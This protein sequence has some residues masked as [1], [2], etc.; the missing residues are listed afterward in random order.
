MTHIQI[1]D[2]KINN[3]RSLVKSLESISGTNVSVCDN[4]SECKSS[5]LTILPGVGKFGIASKALIDFGFNDV[6][7]ETFTKGDKI[8]G[9]CLGMQL[10]GNESEESP[11]SAGLGLIPGTSKRL[12]NLSGERIPHIG[13]AEVSK[14]DQ[15]SF[16]PAQISEKDFYFVH[17]YYFEPKSE[18]NIISKTPYGSFLFPSIIG[19]DDCVIGVQFHPEKSSN[20]GQQFL[21]EII[22]WA[23]E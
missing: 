7:S 16:S 4:Y 2:L 22:K 8:L 11:G 6:L 17:S 23:N 5:S 19:I 14:V 9:I 13:W 15:I 12:P 21:S 18:D 1:I 10:L 20:I 3:I